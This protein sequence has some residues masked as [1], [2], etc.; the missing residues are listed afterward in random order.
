MPHFA[1]FTYEIYLTKGNCLK[2]ENISK[3]FYVFNVHED[4]NSMGF[5]CF[6]YKERRSVHESDLAISQFF[7]TKVVTTDCSY[8]ISICSDARFLVFR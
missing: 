1:K 8:F 5:G 3:V 2:I 7:N 6:R 4:P